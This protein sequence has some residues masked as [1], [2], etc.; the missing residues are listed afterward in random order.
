[1]TIYQDKSERTEFLRT[2]KPVRQQFIQPQM[3]PQFPMAPYG[4]PQMNP[5]MPNQFFS[6]P[7]GGIPNPM[8]NPMVNPMGNPYGNP[9]SGN[10]AGRPGNQSK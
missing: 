6:G 4:F 5:M 3:R 1:V 8:G 2:T 7:P 9:L 10:P